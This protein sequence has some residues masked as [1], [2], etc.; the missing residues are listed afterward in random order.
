MFVEHGPSGRDNHG[1]NAGQTE[2]K[3]LT[4]PETP[5]FSLIPLR[6]TRHPVSF[7]H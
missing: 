7:L 2:L 1:K 3:A 5:A 6:S 4:V